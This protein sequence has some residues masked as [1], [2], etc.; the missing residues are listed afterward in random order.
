MIGEKMQKHWDKFTDAE[1]QQI[2]ARHDELRDR[3]KSS[4]LGDKQPNSETLEAIQESENRRG[5]QYKNADAL[6]SDIDSEH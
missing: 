5:T 6:F 3:G 4:E 2:E 1:K